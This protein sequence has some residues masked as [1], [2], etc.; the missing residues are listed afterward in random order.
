MVLVAGLNR[1]F[2]RTDQHAPVLFHPKY[3]VGP[4]G[5]DGELRI[6]Y[7]TLARRAMALQLDREMKAEEM[8]L[9]YV[10]M[11]RARE[12]LILVHTSTDWAKQYAKLAPDAGTKPDPE[13][14][15]ALSTVGE[16][17]LLPVL[18]RPDA[19]DLRAG[20]WRNLS[21]SDPGGPLGDSADPGSQTRRQAD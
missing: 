10:A 8:R 6:E 7:P 13:A 21:A 19:A 11:T 14:L 5:L 20:R 17:L 9:L 3:G 18:A 2:N 15:N 12:K 16:W 4:S 1:S